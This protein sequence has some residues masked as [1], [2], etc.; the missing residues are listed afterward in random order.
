M[1]MRRALATSA[2]DGVAIAQTSPAHDLKHFRCEVL[3]NGVAV[4]RFD[5][6]DNKVNALNMETVWYDYASCEII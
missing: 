3:D 2:E 4:I 6:V 5:R 1:E